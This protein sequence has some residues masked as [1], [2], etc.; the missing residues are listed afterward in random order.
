MVTAVIVPGIMFVALAG[1]GYIRTVKNAGHELMLTTRI[2]REHAAK[3]FQTNEVLLQKAADLLTSAGP[4]SVPSREKEFHEELRR[5]TANIAQAR[6]VT[7]IDKDGHIVASSLQFPVARGLSAADRAYFINHKLHGVS[8]S[9]NEIFDGRIAKGRIFT[10]SKRL[11]GAGAEFMGIVAI[12]L[13]PDYFTQ[14]Y[15]EVSNPGIGISLFKVDG[16]VIARYP[17]L[18]GDWRGYDRNAP[19]MKAISEGATEGIVDGPSTLDEPYR[20]AAFHQIGA[21]P[22]Y[23]AVSRTSDSVLAETRYHIATLAAFV[24]P[25]WLALMLAVWIALRRA[26][27]EHDAIVHWHKE[28]TRRAQ[29]EDQLRQ[30]HK[31]EA[32]GEL[33]GGLAHDFNNLL[34]TV[35]TTTAALSLLPR[36]ADK[37]PH[38]S[39]LTRVVAGGTA[40]IKH[41]LA[42]ARKQPLAFVRIRTSDAVA[43]NCEL[44]KLLLPRTIELKFEVEPGIHDI[45]A[46]AAELELAIINLTVNARDAM[47]GGGVITVRAR[48]VPAGTAGA[49]QLPDAARDF[50]A[51]SVSDTGTGI[52]E[53]MLPRVFE[54]YFTTKKEKGTGL[55]LSRVY[56][57]VTQLGG[58]VTA[59]NAAGR[60]GAVITLY[61]PW[62]EPSAENP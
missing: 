28:T 29:A 15:S 20:L 39:A 50:V 33:T 53:T 8:T 16:E 4:A 36:D 6:G 54:P 32:L 13:S 59:K 12:A 3:V 34:H 43:A 44:A 18:G 58:H 57:F 47:P 31:Y 51:I 24:V 19:L 14:F 60:G 45:V 30:L 5:L 7:V 9:V 11:D 41:L 17:D 1:Y 38:L 55:G 46:D 61:L 2:V 21:Y 52:P 42:F 26:R 25:T 35:S 48:N 62:A 37:Q 22:V 23:V 40:L 27:S 49:D 56:G 10:V